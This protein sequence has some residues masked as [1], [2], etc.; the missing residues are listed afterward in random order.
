MLRSYC[1]AIGRKRPGAGPR[2]CGG[3][4]LLFLVLA[5]PASVVGQSD[6]VGPSLDKP[7][8]GARS[9]AMSPRPPGPGDFRTFLRGDLR[10]SAGLE[11]SGV[12]APPSFAIQSLPGPPIDLSGAMSRGPDDFRAFL[13]RDLRTPAGLELGR[14]P[15][16]PSFAFQ[17]LPGLPT[18]LSGNWRRP[19]LP[20]FVLKSR[21]FSNGL[22]Q[23]A[24]KEATGQDLFRLRSEDRSRRIGFRP[25]ANF[26]RASFGMRL[27][28]R[29]S[30]HP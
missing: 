24:L 1:N 8:L 23:G 28:L 2:S 20:Q 4:G 19:K 26:H 10:T 25:Y 3:G 30:P 16:P 7:Q 29:L 12:P 21:L 11:L 17:S 13:R 6:A 27:S 22:M 5:V 14:A 15:A 18:D 9:F